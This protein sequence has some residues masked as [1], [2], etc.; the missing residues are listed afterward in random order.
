[1]MTEGVEQYLRHVCY[2]NPKDFAA[3]EAAAKEDGMTLD[4][5]VRAAP[6]D[7]IGTR[8]LELGQPPYA[9]RKAQS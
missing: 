8:A 3:L 6:Y 1:M 4:E 9:A 7:Y 2:D 5:V